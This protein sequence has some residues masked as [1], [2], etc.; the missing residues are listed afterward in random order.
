MAAWRQYE[1]IKPMGGP[2][3]F[4]TLSSSSGT[5]GIDMSSCG[6]STCLIAPCLKFDFLQLC[7]V[8]GL[9]QPLQC[10]EDTL[11]ITWYSYDLVRFQQETVL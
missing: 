10:F 1:G 11:G 4:Q 3:H 5:S 8:H 6:F 7:A 9:Y 2:G